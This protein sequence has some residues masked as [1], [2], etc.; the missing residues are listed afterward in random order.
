MHMMGRSAT[1]ATVD[2]VWTTIRD[3]AQEM[4]RAEPLVAS[5]VHAVI[6]HHD[7]LEDALSFRLAQK[8]GHADL[9]EMVLREVAAKAFEGDPTLGAAARADIVA[10]RERDPACHRHIDPVLFFKGFQALV[11]HRVANWLWRNGRRDLA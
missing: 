1:L 10:V 11:A 6:L 3:E 7:S 9:P 5:L 4:A 2:P 8:L